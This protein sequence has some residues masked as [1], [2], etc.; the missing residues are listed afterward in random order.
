M[1]IETI[2]PTVE[3]EKEVSTDTQFF[4]DV[5]NSIFNF[6][7]KNPKLT[8]LIGL[9]GCAALL[10]L[11]AFAYTCCCSRF[12]PAILRNE[13]IMMSTQENGYEAIDDVENRRKEVLDK[14]KVLP[15]SEILWPEAK[16]DLEFYKNS[17][18]V[19]NATTS[20]SS[21]KFYSF[22]INKLNL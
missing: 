19:N 2:S 1:Y 21:V 22:N 10:V 12:R 13:N 9:A 17:K 11:C 15:V 14:Q 16:Y 6:V 18:P 5:I 8:I 3:L 7:D 20:V 4:S